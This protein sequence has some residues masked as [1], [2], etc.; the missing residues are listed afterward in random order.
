LLHWIG[1]HSEH[2]RYC[3]RGV[4]RSYVPTTREDQR[5]VAQ[6]RGLK[7]RVLTADSGPEIDSAF[8][9]LTREPVD[10]LLVLSDPVYLNQ[11]EH[12]DMHVL[13]DNT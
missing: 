1:T 3:G 10:A 12:R 13:C 5:N 11:R 6:A 9:I 8:N 4:E 7:V 2:D